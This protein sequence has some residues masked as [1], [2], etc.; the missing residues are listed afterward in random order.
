MGAEAPAENIIASIVAF[1]SAYSV[2][3]AIPFLVR[4]GRRAVRRALF[5]TLTFSIVSIG[6]FSMRSPFDAMHPKRL[7]IVH[8]E[9]V[10][11]KL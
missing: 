6:V 5:V 1:I 7:Y 9:N 4:F 10:S 3:L 2:P 11:V 8:S